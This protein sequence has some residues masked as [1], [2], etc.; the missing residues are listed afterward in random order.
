MV[1]GRKRQ[2]HAPIAF[3][4]MLLVFT[5][6]VNEMTQNGIAKTFFNERLGVVNFMGGW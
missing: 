2:R 6:R 5:D 1:T 4:G 3:N